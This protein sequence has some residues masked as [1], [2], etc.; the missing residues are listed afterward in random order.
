M[1]HEKKKSTRSKYKRPDAER[2][3]RQADRMARVLRVLQLIQGKGR[4]DAKAIAH[5]M[6]CSE[7][8]VYRDLTV[9][10]LA[11]VPWTFDKSSSCYRVRSD[12]QFPVLNLTEEELLGQAT[13]TVASQAP[14]LNVN[15]GAKPTS[16]KVAARAGGN[17]ASILSEAQRFT[18]VLDLKLVDHERHRE[19]IRTVQLALL[20]KKQIT[21]HYQSPYECKSVK[22]T[23]HP[24]R[25][26]LIKQAWYLIG[27][28]DKEKEPRTYRIVR[29]QSLRMTDNAAN[30][31]EEFDW[32]AYLGNAWGVYRGEKSYQVELLFDPDMAEIIQ[33]TKWHPTQQAKKH[34]DGT[35]SLCFTVD[36]LNEIVRWII[37]YAGQVRV[38]APKELR[39]LVMA[40]HLAALEKNADP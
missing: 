40:R 30:I 2:R 1:R 18:Q 33:E 5:E 36:G 10:E 4:W 21:G 17:S 6:E 38:I 22:L 35:V 20:Q 9:L 23:L 3:L 14:G 27:Q 32:M 39:D 37:G 31:P 26:A 8:T 28:S 15:L 29:F 16:E 34:R 7:R 12:Y 19:M 24:I 11:G 13:A 25:L